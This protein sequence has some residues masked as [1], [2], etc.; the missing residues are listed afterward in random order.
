MSLSKGNSLLPRVENVSVSEGA[1]ASEE[2]LIGAK[3]KR[4]GRFKQEIAVR[5]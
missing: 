4:A 1:E 3:T 5:E 2:E